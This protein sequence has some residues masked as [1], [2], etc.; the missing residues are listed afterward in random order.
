MI[1]ASII[2]EQLK[3]L[4]ELTALR[5]ELTAA[6]VNEVLKLDRLDKMRIR[7][8]RKRDADPEAE[9]QRCAAWRAEKKGLGNV[10]GAH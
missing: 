7:Q 10:T 3:R 8:R 4:E 6:E 5:R 2:A 1:R 9:R